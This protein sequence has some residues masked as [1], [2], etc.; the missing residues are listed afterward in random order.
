[1]RANNRET[2]TKK[3]AAVCVCVSVRGVCDLYPAARLCFVCVFAL[4]IEQQQ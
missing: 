1:M 4:F 3:K 2:A